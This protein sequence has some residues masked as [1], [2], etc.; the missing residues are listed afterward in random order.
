MPPAQLRILRAVAKRERAGQYFWHYANRYQMKLMYK[1]LDHGY[2]M[3][4]ADG[5]ML[6]VAP[7]GWKCLRSTSVT[8]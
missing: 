4:S 7:K 6:Y 5:F 1:L 8:P 2:M 3:R